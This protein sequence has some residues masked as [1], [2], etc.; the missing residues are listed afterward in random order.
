MNIE[1]GSVVQHSENPMMWGTVVSVFLHSGTL[2]VLSDPDS[3]RATG[4]DV[5]CVHV[6]KV[7]PRTPKGSR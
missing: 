3:Q 7:G 2:R 4:V 1:K 6:S 5:F